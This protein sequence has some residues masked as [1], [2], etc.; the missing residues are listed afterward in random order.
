MTEARDG[1]PQGPEARP[2]D[3]D[4]LLDGG[5]LLVIGS[6]AGD[7]RANCAGVI[8]A[9]REAGRALRILVVG[10][11]GQAAHLLALPPEAVDRVS[12]PGGDGTSAEREGAIAAIAAAAQATGATAWFGPPRQGPHGGLAD[13][14]AEASERMPHARLYAHGAG[15]EAGGR[16]L[17][18]AAA[19]ASETYVAVSRARRSGTIPAAYFEQLYATGT[20]PWGFATSAYERNKYRA[21]LEA[22]PHARYASA[23]EVGCSIG[24]FTRDLAGRCDGL[25]GL[26]VAEGALIEARERCAD[27]SHVRFIRAQVPGEWPEGRFDLIVLSEVAYYLDGPDLDRLVGRMRRALRPGGDIAMVHWLGPTDYP[28]TGDEAAEAVIRGWAGSA[29]VL[30]RTRTAEYRL[31]VLRAGAAAT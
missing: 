22:L 11:A 23:L 13:L 4:A 28:L 21:L 3:L 8:A 25:V 15:P 27:L 18:L 20:D 5:G 19:P 31:D 30:V 24:I 14:V 2:V 17:R 1:T 12:L 29:R 16:R 7:I 26:D 9:A 10:D 6:D